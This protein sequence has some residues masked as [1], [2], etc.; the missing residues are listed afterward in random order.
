MI[1]ASS[2]G[3]DRLAIHYA[4]KANPYDPVLR[5]FSE[6]V[7]GFDIA[8]GGELALVRAA[9]PVQIRGELVRA[10]SEVTL[11]EAR[12]SRLNQ[13]ASEGIIAQ[14]RADEARAALAQARASLAEQRRLEDEYFWQG[15]ITHPQCWFG[16]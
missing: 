6:L 14:A 2:T 3:S 9:E 15:R 7:D 10:Q 1:T 11:A 16:R 8:S 13:L 5:A 12:A 4:V